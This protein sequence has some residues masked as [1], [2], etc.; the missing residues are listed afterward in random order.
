MIGPFFYDPRQSVPG[1]DSFSPSAGKPARFMELAEHHYRTTPVLPVIPVT[2]E[3]LCLVHDRDYVD[4]VFAGAIDNGF[5][6]RDMRVPESCLW[7]VGS[8]VTAALYA[9]TT[10]LAVCSPTS[11]FHHAGYAHGGG[12][13]TFNGLMVAAAKFIEAH[14]GAKVGILDCDFHY[15]DGTA[16][17]LRSKPE[18]A[19][20][21]VHHTSG[22][23]FHEGDD[24]DEFFLWLEESVADINA[25][26]CAVTLYQAGADMHIDDPL[27]GLL[28]DAQMKQ[29]DRTVFRKVL[30]GLVWNLAGGYRGGA[31]IFNDP[32]LQT[33][34]AT[35]GE[36]NASDEARRKL[37]ELRRGTRG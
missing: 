11:G 6:N 18:L 16:D 26:G 13:C 25:Q 9:P 21:V 8:L 4:G 36:A 15:G 17:I 14:P 31:D 7:T 30:G 20:H 23:H 27:G 29:R 37:F 12:Y 2:R 19:K 3:D 34:R 1:L 22:R 33:H 32:T 28:D 5:G 10:P 24:P 35:L